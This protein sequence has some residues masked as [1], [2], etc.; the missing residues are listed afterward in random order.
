MTNRIL[1]LSNEGKGGKIRGQAMREHVRKINLAET[2][3][4]KSKL[5][6]KDVEELDKLIKAG[7]AKAH[8]LK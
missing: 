1:T 3:G 4:R 8:A 2:I 7:I 5:T 6:Q